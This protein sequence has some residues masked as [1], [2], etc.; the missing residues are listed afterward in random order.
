LDD[1][2]KYGNDSPRLD[3]GRDLDRHT[4]TRE[5]VGDGQDFQALPIGTAILHEVVCPYLIGTRSFNGSD[6]L[7]ISPA[8]AWPATRHAEALVPPQSV[9]PLDIDPSHIA[10]DQRVRPPVAIAWV[11]ARNVMQARGEL[12]VLRA[13]QDAWLIPQTE[14]ADVT[15]RATA[16]E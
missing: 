13:A 4:F 3:T 6:D 15:E 5:L 8:F 16:T 9:H 14:A 12:L 11:L 7:P 2:R 10:R 1:L